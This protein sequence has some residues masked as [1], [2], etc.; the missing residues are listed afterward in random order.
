MSVTIIEPCKYRLPC[1][2]CELKEEICMC[3]VPRPAM[4][5]STM[6]NPM[7]IKTTYTAGE[8]DGGEE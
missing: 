8:M 1:G 2:W 4:V 5:Q 3:L 7:D 6:T